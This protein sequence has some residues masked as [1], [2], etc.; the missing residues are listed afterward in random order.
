MSLDIIVG[1]QWGDEGKGRVV[2]LMS[3]QAQY[4]AR[5]NGGDNAGHTVTVGERTFKLHL[6]PSGL[7]HPHT[8]GVIGN[9]LVVNPQVLINE[10]NALRAMGLPVNPARLMISYAAHLI[11][12]AHLA[13]DRA[14]EAARGADKIGTTL[15]GIGPAYNDKAARTGLRMETMRSPEQAAE[16]VAEHVE[17]VNQRLTQLYQ[18]EPLDA[19]SIAADYAGYAQQ[20]QAYIGDVATLLHNAL[21][22]GKSVLAEGAQGTLL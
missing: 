14:R 9:G 8:V 3:A 22:S 18:A 17:A 15:R 16:R 5:Y 7:I 6:L 21:N 4:V 13:L 19:S 2:D 1:A 12:P 10:I 20:L 11:T